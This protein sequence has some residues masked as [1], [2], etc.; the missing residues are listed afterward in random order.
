MIR[1]CSV[2][3]EMWSQF[4]AIA[5]KC[6][7]TILTTPPPPTSHCHT[8]PH[9]TPPSPH[10]PSQLRDYPGPQCFAI[11]GNH[12]WI[13]GLDTFQ[14]HFQ[15]KGWLGGWLLPQ[16]NSYFALRLPHGWW[17]LA[18]DLVLVGDIGEC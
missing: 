8:H 3:M 7:M 13:D 14:R 11:P 1:S 17:L 4:V 10:P 16:S 2:A 9:P 6:K 18:L 5:K 15:H 12:D